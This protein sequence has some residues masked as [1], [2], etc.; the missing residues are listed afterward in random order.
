[1]LTSFMA[2]DPVIR[3]RGAGKIFRTWRRA[4]GAGLLGGFLRRERSEFVALKDIDLDIPKGQLVGLIGAN[5]AGKTTLV[6][7]LSG[8]VPVT[9]G[10]ATLFGRDCFHLGDREKRRISLVM[11]Q[12]SQLWWD[13]P[14]MDSFRLLREIYEVEGAVFERRVAAYAKRL[15]VTDRLDVQLRHLSLGQ[16]MKMEIIG[17]FLHEPEL[18]FLDEPTIGLDLVSQEII[19]QFLRELNRE[20]GVTIVLTSHDMADIEQTCERLLILDEGSLLFDGDLV[21]LQRRLVER[22]AVEIH[23]EP[24][25]PGW[26]PALA[27]EIAPFGARLVREAPLLLAFDLPA[28]RAHGFIKHLFDLFEVRDLAVERQPLEELIRRIFLK[29]DAS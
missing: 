10:T 1:M 20:A 19:R 8:I 14:A 5:G 17:A 27:A 2:T 12:R 29:G 11:G 16:R 25:T 6:K 9:S 22:R 24:G 4:P 26:R 28:D 7:C 15:D 13:I 21:D 3:C 18:V 23:L